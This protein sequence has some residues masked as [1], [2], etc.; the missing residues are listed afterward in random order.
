MEFV[1]SDE[2]K[3]FSSFSSVEFSFEGE[4][5]I[6][7]IILRGRGLFIII[8]LG[9]ILAPVPRMDKLLK[10]GLRQLRL[11]IRY[12]PDSSNQVIIDKI[13]IREKVQSL[14]EFEEEPE[15]WGVGSKFNLEVLGLM[16]PKSIISKDKI[17]VSDAKIETVLR[18]IQESSESENLKVY[19]NPIESGKVPQ[20]VLSLSSVPARRNLL[21]SLLTSFKPLFPKRFIPVDGETDKNAEW[22][23]ID[24]KSVLV[25]IFDPKIRLEIDLDGKLEKEIGMKSEDPSE[26]MTNFINSIPRNI[27][28]RPNFIDKFLIKKQK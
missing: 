7:L 20:I 9:C 26:F 5:L 18:F 3:N 27:A 17:P 24:M 21:K 6:T 10:R 23:I 19:N 4:V 12:K 15:E 25:H 1:K 8:K 14:H 22:I 2:F 28:S 16:E 11:K 13:K